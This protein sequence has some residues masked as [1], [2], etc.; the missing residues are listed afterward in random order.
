MNPSR[1]IDDE[2]EEEDSYDPHLLR[3]P[4]TNS[5]HSYYNESSPLHPKNSS[6]SYPSY[7]TSIFFHSPFN[8][9]SSSR[10]PPMSPTQADVERFVEIEN[11]FPEN[12]EKE[13]EESSSGDE[14]EDKNN[15]KK[16][17][18]TKEEEEEEDSSLNNSDSNPLDWHPMFSAPTNIPKPES[19]LP[20]PRSHTSKSNP[21]GIQ[22]I[23]TINSISFEE[24][25]EVQHSLDKA[26]EQIS[27]LKTRLS[28][29]N[30]R[31]AMEKE[32]LERAQLNAKMEGLKGKIEDLNYQ[33]LYGNS[34]KDKEIQILKSEVTRL[35]IS[36][37]RARIQSSSSGTGEKGSFNLN[38]PF[39]SPPS[40]TPSPSS[41]QGSNKYSPSSS[42]S[43]DS[44]NSSPSSNSPIINSEVSRFQDPIK[45]EFEKKDKQNKEKIVQRLEYLLKGSEG[46]IADYKEKML[47]MEAAYLREKELRANDREKYSQ[48]LQDKESELRKSQIKERTLSDRETYVDL[49]PFSRLAAMFFCCTNLDQY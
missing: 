7:S 45:L 34:Q 1:P 27:L 39:G 19:L 24:Y 18:D 35:R 13:D 15:M 30:R 46:I 41:S 31:S 20:T 40:S 9:S 8:N 5:N 28:S 3:V 22:H 2:E 47:D 44:S 43:D 4:N 23:Q 48:L 10:T 26:N 29:D 14:E 32:K 17:T 6:L 11:E 33:I 16:T 12:K 21:L 49:R 37:T 42:P 25:R 36:E 38:S